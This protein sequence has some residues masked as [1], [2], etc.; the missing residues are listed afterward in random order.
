MLPPTRL[1][2]VAHFARTTPDKLAVSDLAQSRRYSYAEFDAAIER[3]S[4]VL[5]ETIG[6]P[7]GQRVMVVA[8][9]R[10]EML[11][12]HFACIRCGAIFVPVNWRLAAA[13]VALILADCRPALIVAEP[14]LAT[15]LAEPQPATTLAN[16][17]S[18]ASRES[19]PSSDAPRDRDCT[20]IW[21]DASPT[22]LEARMA[23]AGNASR[24][25][26]AP[27][28]ARIT[29]APDTPITLLYSSGTT[30]KSKGVIITLL[31]A[32]A[33]SL[34]L[35]LDLRCGADSVF[36]CDMPLFHT[37]GLLAAARTPLSVGGTVL[38]SQKF[39]APLTYE[40]LGDDRLGITHYFCVTQMAMA[41]RQLPRFD[42]HRLARL[43]ALITGGAPNPEAHIRRWLIEGVPMINAWGMSEI[44]SGTAQPLGDLQRLLANPSAIGLPHMTLD[45]KLVSEGRESGTGE[46][47]EIWVRGWSVTPGYWERPDLDSQAFVD[48]W[49]RTGD[50]AV[51]DGSGSYTLIDRIKDMYISGGENVY[52][53]EIE[54][55]IIELAGV[56]D[57]AVFGVP[58]ETWGET[59][60]AWVVIQP[61]SQLDVA[62]IE[63]HCNARLAR[64]KVPR[65]V[66]IVVSLPR[67]AAGKI[68]KHLLR[69]A[70]RP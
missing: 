7:S 50:V 42:G 26:A 34:N 35:A 63:A 59:G 14:E 16:R 20:R 31:N 38:I 19:L 67:T 66:Q 4:A 49:F 60:A 13:E 61:G 70:H 2:F 27:P 28:A 29:Q 17:E 8:R 46:P 62:T 43:T 1:D 22:G 21:L 30:G 15:L 6:D 56:S 57:V 47:G 51:R 64:F 69:A 33:S 25:S 3:A 54:A 9:N 12:L 65:F 48:G 23:T 41:M 53:A 39:D 45:M 18:P 36:L 58:H 11:I 10:A 37:A 40:R 32:F 44:G 52:P 24:T 5:I 68:Q 55:A